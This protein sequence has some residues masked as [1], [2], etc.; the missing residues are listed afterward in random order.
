MFLFCQWLVQQKLLF[1]W[2]EFLG[3][4]FSDVER[5][6]FNF[7]KNNIV[8]LYRRASR[9]NGDTEVM[10]VMMLCVILLIYHDNLLLFLLNENPEY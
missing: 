6:T 1:H 10:K 3:R 4:E 5:I 2:R 9:D 8:S 7:F